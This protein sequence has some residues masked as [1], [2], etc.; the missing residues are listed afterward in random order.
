MPYNNGW[1]TFTSTGVMISVPEMQQVLDPDGNN[2]VVGPL[3]YR[4]AI[5]TLEN[6][7]IG[8]C[9]VTHIDERAVIW[10]TSKGFQQFAGTQGGGFGAVQPW[11]PAMGAF[12]HDTL[13]S[14]A[15]GALEDQFCIE[16]ACDQGW[17]FVSSRGNV[18]A[19]FYSRAHVYQFDIDRWGSFNFEHLFVGYDRKEDSTLLEDVHFAFIDAGS[20]IQLV[21]HRPHADAWVR[22][23]PQ[24]LQLPNEIPMPATS[25][26]AV[27][28]I[29]LGTKKPAHQKP[30][31]MKLRS[32]WLAE[33]RDHI[34]ES[35]FYLMISGGFDS[36]SQ[37][38]DEG[39]YATLLRRDEN[40]AVYTC[41]N[42]GINHTLLVATDEPD[43]FFQIDHIEI[44]YILAGVL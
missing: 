10:L 42:T 14:N 11:Q 34:P 26:T 35:N 27:Q 40:T 44:T 3:V 37:N 18:F 21:D 31:P 30:Q 13:L 32:S 22:L 1:L 25:I 12:Y 33:K 6:V 19:A 2:I 8:P 23:T 28:Q 9:A 38:A 41:H 43:H 20:V 5:A 39:E 7:L 36:E 24:R 15:A 16:Y 29:R 17:L 4:H